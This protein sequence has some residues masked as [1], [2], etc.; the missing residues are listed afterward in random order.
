MEQQKTIERR[1][2]EFKNLMAA[3][4]KFHR[5]ACSSEWSIRL[6]KQQRHKLNCKK[7]IN[8]TIKALQD[9]KKTL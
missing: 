4:N 5:L 6:P 3:I 9:F 2:K 1:E 7:H 8:Y